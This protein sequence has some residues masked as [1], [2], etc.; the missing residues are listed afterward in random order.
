M[1][2]AGTAA[3]SS[4]FGIIAMMS[5]SWIGLYTAA[6]PALSPPQVEGG[7]SPRRFVEQLGDH[8]DVV[9]FVD[10]V[11]PRGA[12]GGEGDRHAAEHHL[13]GKDRPPAV[14]AVGHVEASDDRRHAEGA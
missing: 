11:V 4:S 13:H 5:S 1:V 6:P 12:A 8:R 14:V 2:G 9:V 10:R 7:R 3:L